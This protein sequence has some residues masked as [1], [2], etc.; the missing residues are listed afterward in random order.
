[1]NYDFGIRVD[2]GKDVGSGHFF[3]CLSI[4]KK[5][6]ENGFKI[7]FIV[8]NKKEFVAHQNGEQ[9]PFKV[10]GSIDEN[11]R[12]KECKILTKNISNFIIDLPFNSERYSELLKNCCKVII[13][14]DLGNKKIFSQLL[15][16]GSIVNEFQNY[17]IDKKITKYFVGPQYIILRP[18]F[19]IIREKIHSPNKKLQRILLT[20]GGN[21]DN[22]VTR[23]IISYF[24]N[25]NFDITIVLGP[26]Y[27]HS[28]NLK[29]M[30]QKKK[31][32]KIISNEKNIARLFAEQDL[33]ISSSGITVYELAC[34]GIPCILIPSDV[35][36][37]KTAIEM[38]KHGFGIHYGFWDDDF[39]KLDRIISSLSN[40]SIREKMCLIGRKLVDGKGLSRITKIICEL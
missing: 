6:I 28:A 24:Y 32:F 5:L 12:I 11:E 17:S 38:E 21:D 1:M 39:S 34:L 23:R 40:Y 15:F 7:I 13:I 8:N 33:V 31:N 16:N 14:D 9:I 30:I 35:H 29:E 20:F 36:Q 19:E 10:L 4:G 18:E 22:D 37:K 26:S 27:K 3:R 25:K 2:I